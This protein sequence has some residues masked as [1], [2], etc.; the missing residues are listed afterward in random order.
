MD[1]HN[2]VTKI[3]IE[4]RHKSGKSYLIEVRDP[5]HTPG[6]VSLDYDIPMDPEQPGFGVPCISLRVNAR[7][8]G[9]DLYTV[10]VLK[11]ETAPTPVPKVEQLQKI[12]ALIQDVELDA[13][14]FDWIAVQRHC[15]EARGKIGRA[16][17][18]A[19]QCVVAGVEL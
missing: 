11:P 12:L 17:E 5:I 10:T 2:V 13:I 8:T 3:Q 1:D 4:T 7:K 16:I 18:A 19:E 14:D 15:Q 6:M 9:A